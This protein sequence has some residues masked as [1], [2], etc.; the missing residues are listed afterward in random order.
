MIQEMMSALG[1][2]QKELAAARKGDWRERGKTAGLASGWDRRELISTYR[3]QR[4]FAA[5]WSP[6]DEADFFEV[7]PFPFG[8]LPVNCR[9]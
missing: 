4:D 7:S 6:M 3:I 8:I 2:A 1:I 5:S 9:R